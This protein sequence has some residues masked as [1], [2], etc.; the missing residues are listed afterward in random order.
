MSSVCVNHQNLF[1]FRLNRSTYSKQI[2]SRAHSISLLF[3]NEDYH[4]PEIKKK[5]SNKAEY[6]IHVQVE[7]KTE[8]PGCTELWMCWT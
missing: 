1:I 5:E 4:V 2:E 6:V 7:E 3:L 8:L